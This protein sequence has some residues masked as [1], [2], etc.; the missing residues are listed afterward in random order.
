M[1]S[2]GAPHPSA[3]GILGYVPASSGLALRVM[4]TAFLHGYSGFMVTHRQIK[5]IDIKAKVS[6]ENLKL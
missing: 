6:S 5:V 2:K 4:K 3:V 1:R